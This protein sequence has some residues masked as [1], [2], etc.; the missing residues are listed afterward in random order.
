MV[1]LRIYPT[2]TAYFDPLFSYSMTEPNYATSTG[3]DSRPISTNIR[4]STGNGNA[5]DANLHMGPRASMADPGYG[6]RAGRG[7]DVF[8][9]VTFLL[10]LVS[11]R[12]NE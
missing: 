3:P 7:P 1:L 6:P 11:F 10:S 9:V 5:A 2:P 12:M 4:A 8:V